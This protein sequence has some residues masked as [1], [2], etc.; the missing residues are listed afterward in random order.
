VSLMDANGSIHSPRDSADAG[1]NGWNYS[2]NDDTEIKRRGV[3]HLDPNS[4]DGNDSSHLG[5]TKSVM[6]IEKKFG[7]DEKLINQFRQSDGKVNFRAKYKFAKKEYKLKYKEYKKAKRWGSWMGW[8]RC[9][10]KFACW[11]ICVWIG[12]VLIFLWCYGSKLRKPEWFWDWLQGK[13]KKE[14]R[15]PYQY[16]PGGEEIDMCVQRARLLTENVPFKILND[17]GTVTDKVE[18]ASHCSTSFG[19]FILL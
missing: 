13:L 10:S 3:N 19:Y 11:C 6:L 15:R 8:T 17:D 1:G 9:S 7:S 14:G 4:P 5:M 16:L 2:D 12:F 18:Q